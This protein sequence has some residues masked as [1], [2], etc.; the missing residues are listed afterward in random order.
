MWIIFFFFFFSQLSLAYRVQK[1]KT[2]RRVCE[3]LYFPSSKLETVFKKSYLH[4]DQ[5]FIKNIFQISAFSCSLSR[6]LNFCFKFW[7]GSL[8]LEKHNFYNKHPFLYQKFLQQLCFK[9]PRYECYQFTRKKRSIF[10]ALMFKFLMV[11]CYFRIDSRI[12][13]F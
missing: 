11:I 2:I 6:S 4:K 8:I 12:Y 13:L 9:K 3:L 10:Y 1:I 7:H 5:I